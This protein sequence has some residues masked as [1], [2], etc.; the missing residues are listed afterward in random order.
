MKQMVFVAGRGTEDITDQLFTR[1]KATQ[2]AGFIGNG[3]HKWPAWVCECQ[4]E[5]KTITPPILAANL[6]SGHT[7]SCGC[8]QV[9]VTIKRSTIHGGASRKAK[10]KEWYAWVAAKGR[11]TNPNHPRFPLYGARG[12]RMCIFLQT[13]FLNFKSV[14]GMCPEDKES[15]GRIN[16]DGHYSCGKCE[17]CLK[18]GWLMN[19]RWE[20]HEEQMNNTSTSTK[21][22]GKS[23]SEIATQEGKTIKQVRLEHGLRER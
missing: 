15:I 3:L 23:V 1:L 21:I 22:N 9:E 5:K 4:C 6:K 19:L 16:N 14:S 13:S 17:E 11:T 12:I 8:I 2:F 20:D 18:S 7:T 10:T